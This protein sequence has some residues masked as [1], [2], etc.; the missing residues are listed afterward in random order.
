MKI[1]SEA[2]LKKEALLDVAK[3]MMIAARTAPKGRGIDNLVIAIIEKETIAIIASKM[4]EMVANG[5]YSEFF[6]RDAENILLS[7]VMLLLGTKINPI[8]LK[9]CGLCGF[10]DCETKNQH[11]DHPCSFNTGDLGIS[12]G[13]A[14]SIASD[15]RVDNRIMFSAGKAVKELNLLGNEVKIIYGI[16]LSASS[17]SP[18]FDR[19]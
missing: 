5:G 2:E 12:I 13:S 15:C 3:Q 8:G 6:I 4:K 14:V 7:E 10:P 19:K 1:I 16:P 11:P 17:K 9:Q 18:F